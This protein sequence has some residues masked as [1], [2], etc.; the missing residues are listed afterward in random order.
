MAAMGMT[1]SRSWKGVTTEV[2]TP[3][4]IGKKG[5]E[6]QTR[7]PNPDLLTQVVQEVIA[8]R[9]STPRSLLDLPDLIRITLAASVE[10]SQTLGI[11]L[12]VIEGLNVVR[13]VYVVPCPS[14]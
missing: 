13:I 7:A 9:F 4:L 11:I 14:A 3:E 2:A 8:C 5:S 12:L 1:C 10:S 6:K